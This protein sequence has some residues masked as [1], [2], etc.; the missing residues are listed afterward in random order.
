MQKMPHPPP[1]LTKNVH[2]ENTFACV[3]GQI[4]ITMN[5][6]SEVIRCIKIQLRWTQVA[7]E[8]MYPQP[9]MLP[10]LHG[11]DPS[12]IQCNTINCRA[13]GQPHT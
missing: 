6:R 13:K 9:T 4:P 5:T 10:Y 1:P 8:T 12:Q 2:F 11:V 7:D 3:S